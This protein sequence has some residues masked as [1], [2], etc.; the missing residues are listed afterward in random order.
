[1]AASIPSNPFCT[2]LHHSQCQESDVSWAHKTHWAWLS[3]QSLENLLQID[4][5]LLHSVHSTNQTVITKWPFTMPRIRCFM[6]TQNTF[7]LIVISIPRKFTPNWFLLVTFDPLNKSVT[8]LQRIMLF[9]RLLY[10]W[11]TT[12]WCGSENHIAVYPLSKHSR[13]AFWWDN[14]TDPY[15][16][17]L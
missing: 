10:D 11:Y 15:P 2:S 9:G 17:V 3:F 4:F 5:S 13:F 8:I 6:S 12:W 16:K 14:E 1:M 7:S